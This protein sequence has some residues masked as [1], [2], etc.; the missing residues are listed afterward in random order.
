MV[1]I[2]PKMN[3]T[4]KSKSIDYLA[5]PSRVVWLQNSKILFSSSYFQKTEEILE[6]YWFNKLHASCDFNETEFISVVELRNDFDEI[7]KN[8]RKS[9]KSL[10]DEKKFNIS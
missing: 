4:S 8:F 5:S 6:K 1:M 3:R 9:Y 2:L 10:I 7:K